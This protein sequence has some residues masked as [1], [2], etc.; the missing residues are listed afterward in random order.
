MKVPS[1][2][3]YEVF[4]GGQRF[5]ERIGEVAGLVDGLHDLARQA[6]APKVGGKALAQPVHL[7]YDLNV[8]GLE[9]DALQGTRPYLALTVQ[10]GANLRPHEYFFIW[11]EAE[12]VKKV[13]R[14]S[15]GQGLGR[16]L[17]PGEIGHGLAHAALGQLLVAAQAEVIV[18][19]APDLRI[20]ALAPLRRRNAF[21]LGFD[22]GLEGALLVRGQG[23]GG[24]RRYCLFAFGPTVHPVGPEGVVTFGLIQFNFFPKLW[25]HLFGVDTGKEGRK[26]SD[27]DAGRFLLAGFG[28][29]SDH[30]YTPSFPVRTELCGLSAPVKTHV[31]DNRLCRGVGLV[32]DGDAKDCVTVEGD[33]RKFAHDVP[34]VI[35]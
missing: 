11:A 32:F 7:I 24:V 27:G 3:G 34:P 29:Y 10:H 4:I 6:R 26:L 25:P 22:D 5:D 1:H 35:Q 13:L 30:R 2:L 20:Q 21:D 15:S 19:A 28:G 16:H 8:A 17:H 33:G 14:F 31:G 18:E 9:Q 23:R 12:A